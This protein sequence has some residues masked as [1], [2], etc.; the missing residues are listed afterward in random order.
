MCSDIQNINALNYQNQKIRNNECI[1]CGQCITV[2]PTDALKYKNSKSSVFRALANKKI[3]V[4]QIAPAAPGAI[5]TGK[6]I[7]AARQLGFKYV[8]D[9]NF[10]ADITV[11]EE[12]NELLRRMKIDV[13]SSLNENN[14]DDD[15]DSKISLLKTL[16]PIIKS[17][18]VFNLNNLKDRLV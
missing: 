11:I 14:N 6:I 16:N 9:T 4:L 10:G 7:Q 18:A 17:T 8:F 15:E 12:A 1:I 5:V 3:L 13:D 2:S